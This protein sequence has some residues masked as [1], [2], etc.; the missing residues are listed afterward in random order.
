MSKV[1]K[2]VRVGRRRIVGIAAALVIGG[3]TV[4]SSGATAQSA[5]GTPDPG[6]DSRMDRSVEGTVLPHHKLPEGAVPA[7][8]ERPR[9][10]AYGPRFQ[11]P[12]AS[13][14]VSPR[15]VGGV[16][17]NATEHPWIIGLHTYFLGY[18]ENGAI[19]EFRSTCT[20]TVLSPTKVLTAGHCIIGLTYG[21]TFAIAGR[22]DLDVASG[23]WVSRV[24]S[25]WT[26]QNFNIG[27]IWNGTANVP[28]DDV[29]VLTLLDPLPSEYTPIQ[30]TAQGDQTP[31]AAGTEALIIG[32]GIRNVNDEFGVLY[33]TTVP[34]TSDAECQSVYGTD[35]DADRM[36][37][38]GDPAAGKDTCNGDSGG[39][40]VVAGVQVGITDWGY[41]PCA[42]TYGVYERLSYYSNA[43]K[44]D[45]TR[46]PLVNLDWSGD[47][48]SDLL[49]RESDGWL[50]EHSGSGLAT[51]GYGGFAGSRDISGGWNAFS[52]LFRVTNWNGD[53][54]RSVFA[55][56]P[57]GELYQYK[58]NGQGEFAGGASLIG[59]GWQSFTDIM[60]TNNWTGDGRPNLMGRL[61]NGDLILYTSNGSGGWLNPRGTKIGTGW[62]GFDTVLTPGAWAGDGHQA[63]IGRRSNGDLVLYK[64]NGAGG[65]VNPRGDLI[66][67]GW[68]SFKIFMSPGDWN[69]DNMVD[70]VGITPGGAMWLYTTNGHGQWLNSRGMQIA[71]GW[72]IYNRIF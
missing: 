63:L 43:V 67:T 66:G 70:L 71:S 2:S 42:S 37:C 64:S 45:L 39:P 5:P 48:H 40:I 33:K 60:V 25:T 58:N 51:D 46:P 27:A 44:A 15:V 36:V 14:S 57:T 68:S 22:N 6:P 69:G 34:M 19:A 47:G 24:S 38:A 55:M 49:T 59:T 18:D 3:G 12:T 26:H 29:S 54:N 4:L 65:W 52:K 53:G 21:T 20:G 23:G 9:P 13:R 35:F 16:P 8:G 61:P 32:Y 56:K 17:A 72:N 1:V 41:A 31:Y 50:V 28:V 62:S 11:K 10:G 7:T 30:L